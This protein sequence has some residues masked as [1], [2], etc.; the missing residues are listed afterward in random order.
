MY[1]VTGT[2]LSARQALRPPPYTALMI[3]L[4]APRELLYR[5]INQRARTML[6]RGLQAETARLLAAGVSPD[7]RALEGIGYG[8]MVQVL[9]GK[10]SR[11]AAVD[12]MARLTRRYARRQLIWF[13]ADPR[14]RWFD[15]TK[16]EPAELERYLRVALS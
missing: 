15:V 6:Q 5:W 2:P 13:A 11:E 4:R 1:E 7:S 12:Q 8:E 14:V 3:G 16:T 10:L 9:E